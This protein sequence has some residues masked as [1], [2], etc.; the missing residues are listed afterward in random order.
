MTPKQ[1]DVAGH[2]GGANVISPTEASP[3]VLFS[4]QLNDRK[5]FSGGDAG[6]PLSAWSAAA[7][8]PG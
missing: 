2:T 1:P 5:A 8:A 3:R 6:V 4:A 7:L